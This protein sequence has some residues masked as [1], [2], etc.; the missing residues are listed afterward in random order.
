MA[1]LAEPEGAPQAW[2]DDVRRYG[3]VRVAGGDAAAVGYARDSGALMAAGGA[4]WG[5]AVIAIPGFMTHYCKRLDAQE[6]FNPM[7]ALSRVSQGGL[8]YLRAWAIVLPTMLTSFL[9]LLGFGV[10]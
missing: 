7:R 6:I 5:M 3:L 9:G 4:L 2:D 8:A 1:R 10:G